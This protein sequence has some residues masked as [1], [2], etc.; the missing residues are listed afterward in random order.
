MQ[1]ALITG[2]SSGIGKELA[3]IMAKAG[4][5]LVLVARNKD[6]LINVK[7][8]IAIFSNVHVTTYPVDL[9]TAGSAQKLYEQTKSE[10][11]EIL[12]NNAGVGLKGDFFHDSLD[13]NVQ[14]ANLNMI[15]L[16]ELCH[17]FGN[18]FL[19][20]NSGK[21]LNIGSIAAF[22]AGPK[23]PVYYATKAFVRNFS[24]ALAY[25]LR[26]TNVTVTTLHPGITKT[27]F[28]TAAGARTVKDGASAHSVAKLGYKAMMNGTVE[29]T[30][31]LHNKILTNVLVRIVPYRLQTKFVDSASDA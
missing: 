8:E 19:Q 9:S 10:H 24:R 14:M 11:V 13:K 27:K 3:K 31:G 15:T 7:K 23:Q 30:H 2:A 26:N 5:D 22:L 12:V 29:V 20:A 16:M 28:F 1:K 18:D 21:I 6:E 25:N 17:L 4:H